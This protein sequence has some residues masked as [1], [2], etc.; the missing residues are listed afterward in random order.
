MEIRQ[1]KSDWFMLVSE[2]DDQATLTFFGYS[3]DE[4]IGKFR[5]WVRAHDMIKLRIYAR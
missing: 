3:K 1:V 4:V 2:A 5:K